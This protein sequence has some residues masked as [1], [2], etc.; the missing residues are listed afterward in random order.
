LIAAGL[1]LNFDGRAAWG[2]C[3]H[4]I[5]N[6]G[7][8]G[9]CWAFGATEALS[10]RF[11]IWSRGAANVVLSPQDLVSCDRYPGCDGCGGGELATAWEFMRDV[12]VV[13]DSC[14]P[15]F[16]KNVACPSQCYNGAQ[17]VMY[18]AENAYQIPYPDICGE[19][20]SH[21]PVEAAFSVY[22]DFV[23]YSGGVYQ[24]TS[25]GYL[26]GHAIKVIGWGYYLGLPYWLCANSWG[27]SWGL[28][29]FFMIRRGVNECG[30]ESYM[31]AGYPKL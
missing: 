10:D 28:S 16:A 17:P 14:F 1:P 18:H 8:C 26:G 29:G 23:H 13:P 27:P 30:I 31:T 20:Y 15:Y 12:G 3:V 19:I 25:G 22:K 2:Q 4:P 9:S 7:N 24:H 11:C 6:Q 5:R 21:G